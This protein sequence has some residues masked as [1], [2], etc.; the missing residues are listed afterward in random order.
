MEVRTISAYE[1]T[2]EDFF[3]DLIAWKVDALIDTRRKNTNQLAGFTKKADLEYFVPTI[4]HADYVHD[5]LFAPEPMTLE[6]YLKG[7][8]GWDEYAASYRADIEKRGSIDHF[9]DVYGDRASVCLLGT[10]T[11]KRR[12]HVEVLKTMIDERL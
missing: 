6:K 1:I 7:A 4:V 8:I 10:A 9:F 3:N 11:H 12:S 5:L 2:A